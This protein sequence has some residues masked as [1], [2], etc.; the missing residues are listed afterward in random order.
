MSG[1]PSYC[2]RMFR[3]GG[4]IERRI[5]MWMILLVSVSNL[6]M[7]KIDLKEVRTTTTTTATPSSSS[8]SSRVEDIRNR[9]QNHYKEVSPPFFHHSS[10]SS[11]QFTITKNNIFSTPRTY[12]SD[13]LRLHQQQMDQQ[14]HHHPVEDEKTKKK[15]NDDSFI[16]DPDD[17]IL[18]PYSSWDNSPIVIEEY[19]LLFFTT[20]KIGSTVFK[21][22]FRRMMK[23]E[24]WDI[25]DGLQIPHSP[26]VNGLQYLFQYDMETI[27]TILTD[28]TWTRAI[29][30]RD[31]MERVLSAYLD[32]GRQDYGFYI[33]RH[34]CGIRQKHKKEIHI[35]KGN[36]TEIE[37]QTTWMSSNK[38]QPPRIQQQQEQNH[39]RLEM[40]VTTGEKRRQYDHYRQ[41]QGG[42]ICGRLDD[43]MTPI[44]WETFV[45]DI[46]PICPDDEHWKT[47]VSKHLRQINFVGR[48]HSLP[49]DTRRLLQH[50]GA[51]EE[52][53]ATGWPSTTTN[54]SGTGAI[55]ETNTI[56]HKTSSQDYM[57]MYYKNSTIRDAV[58]QLYHEDYVHPVLNHTIPKFLQ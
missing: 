4:S 52:Y 26:K 33:K 43:M 36:G 21:Q 29:F 7:T 39:R 28:P 19:K 3:R 42:S 6:L 35:S 53:G 30:T 50:L 8:S 13:I 51:W 25:N 44:S 9:L 16:I 46:L 40:M 49:T 57:A 22:L 31:P 41:H 11:N 23:L 54:G 32:K 27:R 38:Q 37:I 24:D 18:I 47:Q 34:C 12:S 45:L 58:Q 2:C 10:S 17:P 55:F 20:P 15:D 48:F 56:R 1:C 14:Q 5:L